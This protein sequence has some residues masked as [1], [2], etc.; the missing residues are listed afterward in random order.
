[1]SQVAVETIPSEPGDDLAKSLSNDTSVLVSPPEVYLRINDMLAD[2]TA[3]ADDFAK[4]IMHDPALAARMLKL[5]NS[6]YYGLPSK[7][8][9]ISRALTIVGMHELTNLV[10][11]IC[12]IKSFSKMSSDITNMNTFWRHGVYCG[13]AARELAKEAKCI[14]PERLFV[15]GLLHDLG[16][17]A[18]NRKYPDVAQKL[19]ESSAGSE[20]NLATQE[21]QEFGFDHAQLGALML[22]NWNL[23]DATCQAIR[24]H[25]DLACAE[26]AQF[27]A[28]II[29]LADGLANCSGTGCFS[30]I[31]AADNVISGQLLNSL[32]I[33]TDYDFEKLIE[34]VDQKFI[35]TVYLLV[36]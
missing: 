17:L 8:D 14:N 24:F 13:I 34:S 11:S 3:S 7:V 23:P 5:V 31:I 25:H 30:E 33:D 9:T 29:N 19:I 1:M 27:E 2:D 12:A 10:Y 21:R 20:Q 6:S 26:K 15:A 18:I 35:E 32:Q 4:V 22:E 36:A 28:A 16:T